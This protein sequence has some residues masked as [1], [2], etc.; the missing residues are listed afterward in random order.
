MWPTRRS[1]RQAGF[2]LL[3]ILVAFAIMATVVTVLLQVFAGG[4]RNLRVGED[5]VVAATLAESR[6]AELGRS[7]PVVEGEE[8]GAWDRYS[9]QVRIAPWDGLELPDTSDVVL[10]E[11]AVIVRWS[12]GT[13]E[14]A[15]RLSSLRPGLREGAGT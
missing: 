8:A 14:R 10:Y 1:E 7:V 12:E 4:L 2:S 13:R 5:Y 3:E 15:L 11:V 9:W 6:L